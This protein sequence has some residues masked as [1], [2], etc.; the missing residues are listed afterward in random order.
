MNLVDTMCWCL[1]SRMYD[2]KMKK[3]KPHIKDHHRKSHRI[4][5]IYIYRYICAQYAFL[6]GDRAQRDR[7]R[8]FRAASYT[9]QT[10]KHVVCPSMIG[11]PSSWWTPWPWHTHSTIWVSLIMVVYD[12]MAAPVRFKHIYRCGDDGGGKHLYSAQKRLR[13][14]MLCIL[15]VV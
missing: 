8:L 5:Y 15:D 9:T 4:V 14:L 3:K 11:H 1:S 7:T 6:N 2:R 13:D 10:H 12:A